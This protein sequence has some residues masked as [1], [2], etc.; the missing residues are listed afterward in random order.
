MDYSD[1][2]AVVGGRWR[3]GPLGRGHCGPNVLPGPTR[4]SHCWQ[5][6]YSAHYIRADP[7][8]LKPGN[9]ADANK[10]P[11]AGFVQE[12]GVTSDATG[13]T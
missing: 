2:C 12:M 9:V 6:V 13:V 4:W 11:G 7:R 3:N 5:Q 8:G 1:A 10:H